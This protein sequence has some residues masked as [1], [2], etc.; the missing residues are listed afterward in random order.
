MGAARSA[1][2]CSSAIAVVVERRKFS[3]SR[4]PVETCDN[5]LIQESGF[6]CRN[7]NVRQPRPVRYQLF[8]LGSD[9][10]GAEKARS[11]VCC[12]RRLGLEGKCSLRTNTRLCHCIQWSSFVTQNRFTTDDG[13]VRRASAEAVDRRAETPFQ[14]NLITQLI[15]R[16]HAVFLRTYAISV[17]WDKSYASCRR[18]M[19]RST[20]GI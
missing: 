13:L 2:S 6:E 14:H 4:S 10:S 8:V 18:M 15:A 9:W 11:G 12:T 16:K 1:K 5:T 19:R 3:E 20:I 17:P 7:C